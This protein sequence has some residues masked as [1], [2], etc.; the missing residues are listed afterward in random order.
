[1]ASNLNLTNAIATAQ[2]Q[3]IADA[4]ASGYLRLYSGSQPATADTA[5]SGQT[6]L[7]ELR[8]AAV[9]ETS[10]V[11]GVITFAALTPDASAVGGD[12]ATWFRALEAD[13]TTVVLDGTVG[14]AGC[15]LNMNAVAISAGAAVSA[16]T[17]T[18]TVV[19]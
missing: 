7:A 5:V 11:D 3:V 19:K 1:M 14:T 8:F 18:Y 17:M 9:A 12:T 10:V 4:L 2:A 13:G 16:N 15:D 6:K